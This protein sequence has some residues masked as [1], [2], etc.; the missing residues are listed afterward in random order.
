VTFVVPQ[1]VVIQENT[2]PTLTSVPTIVLGAYS[3]VVSADGTY[4]VSAT[5]AFNIS[6]NSVN[7]SFSGSLQALPFDPINNARYYTYTNYPSGGLI[8]NG[9][10]GPGG[11]LSATS[12]AA[13]QGLLVLNQRNRDWIAAQ[14]VALNRERARRKTCSDNLKAQ[15][16]GWQVDGVPIYQT[17]QWLDAQK[18]DVAAYMADQSK[19]LSYTTVTAAVAPDTGSYIETAT[20]KVKITGVLST[21][22]A[23]ANEVRYLYAR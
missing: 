4:I 13:Q 21:A 12:P 6:Y 14:L 10:S 15:L 16:M 3:Q 20:S 22:G 5:Q 7:T 8:F 9:T 23:L 18:A 19:G 1:D 17:T 2:D 11:T